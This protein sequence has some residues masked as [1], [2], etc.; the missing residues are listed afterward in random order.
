MPIGAA[1]G[2][3]GNQ[4]TDQLVVGTAEQRR[5]DMKPLAS[6]KTAR[7]TGNDAG[8]GLWTIRR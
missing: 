1:Q 3:I 8:R 6:T 7:S 5:R 4:S 2:E